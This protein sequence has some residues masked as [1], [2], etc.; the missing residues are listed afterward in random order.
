MADHD[1][2]AGPAGAHGVTI[3]F[4]LRGQGRHQHGGRGNQRAISGRGF[5]LKNTA[6]AFMS[7]AP[8]RWPSG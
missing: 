4:L 3:G 6:Q 2:A 7:W 5:H 1:P 8:E